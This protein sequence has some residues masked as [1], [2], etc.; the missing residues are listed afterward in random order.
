MRAS[1]I[2][3][4]ALIASIPATLLGLVLVASPAQA[5]D[6]A[7]KIAGDIVYLT[8]K[9]RALHG[10]KALKADTRLATAARLHS[11]YMARRGAFSHTGSGGSTFDA[12]IRAASYPRP[13]AENIAYGYRTGLD[14]VKA[15][16]ASPGHRANI[17]NCK[18]NTVGVGAVYAANGTTYFTQ[19]FGY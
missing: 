3:R 16:M 17:L 10:C 19:D 14:V 9:Q 11:S 5:A 4:L 18:A 2:K 8:N 7:A 13:A 1:I 12:R 6:S 15:W